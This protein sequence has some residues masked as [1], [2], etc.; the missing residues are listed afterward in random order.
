MRDFFEENGCL[1]KR[2]P[3]EFLEEISYLLLLSPIAIM[4][5]LLL[6]KGTMTIDDVVDFLS[7]Q[8]QFQMTMMFLLL[9]LL[10]SRLLFY[11]GSVIVFDRASNELRRTF[12]FRFGLRWTDSRWLSDIETV[13]AFSAELT[14]PGVGRIVVR[15]KRGRKALVLGMT[16]DSALGLRTIH[17]LKTYLGL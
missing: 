13:E 11:K 15:F 17:R 4:M 3:Y 9:L 1:V 8:S 10:S 2:E 16:T 7:T 6:W 12:E 14:T 5:A